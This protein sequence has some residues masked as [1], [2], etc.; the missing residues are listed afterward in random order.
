MEPQ[1]GYKEAKKL[2]E[3]HYGSDILIAN[4]YQE[5]ILNWSSINS[6]D[7]RALHSFL[8]FLRGCCNTML[9][10]DAL[11]DMNH[12]TKFQQLVQFIERHANMIIDPL[13]GGFA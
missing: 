8:L 13:Y 2:L 6:E 12:A 4:A 10:V 11:D 9:E 7:G 1:K 3:R 5:R